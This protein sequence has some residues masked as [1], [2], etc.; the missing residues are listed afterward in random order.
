MSVN[1][2]NAADAQQ[3]QKN[4]AMTTATVAGLGLGTAGAIGGYFHK[5][6][7]SLEEV[8]SQEPDTFEASMNK[9]A[10][11]DSEA[12][13]T[14]RNE[15]KA[16]DAD[17]AVAPKLQTA[18]RKANEVKQAIESRAD[19]DNKATLDQAVTDKRNARDA[20][21]VDVPK[22]DGT[23]GTRKIKY[24]EAKSE[25]DA[26]K[27]KVDGLAADAT[28]D[29]KAAAKKELDAA[30]AN[31]AKFDAEANALKE[32]E[33]A[34]F[35][36]KKAKFEADDAKKALREEASKAAD[37]LTN[38]R[39]GL[40]DKLKDKN[41]VT[42]A[43]GKVKKALSEVSWKRVGLYGGIAAAVGLLAGAMLSGK[44]EA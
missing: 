19:Y 8:F 16:I 37:E 39:K 30:K 25:F 34:V 3:P 35:D 7:P 26:A 18:E 22:A 38:A 28:E 40:I 1:A 44:K 43:F 5:V 10:E 6:T 14:L 12:A 9:A 29:A 42:E 13:Q 33:Q 4:N 2:I 23:E 20:K 17:G 21:E 24:A 36:A 11:A 41:T 27:T 31:L 15:M 32:A